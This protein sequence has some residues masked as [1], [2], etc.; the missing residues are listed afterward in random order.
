M[1]RAENINSNSVHGRQKGTFSSFIET[2]YFAIT[3]FC[4]N[5]WESVVSKTQ[6]E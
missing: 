6:G 2:S 4:I 5:L 3:S 1:Y